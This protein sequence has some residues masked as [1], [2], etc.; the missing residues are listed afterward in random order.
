MFPVDTKILIVDDSSFARTVLKTGLRDLKFWK[1]LE[2]DSAKSAI[3]ILLEPEQKKD[4]VHLLIADV[5]M[6]EMNGLELLRWV[7]VQD[8]FRAMPVII[9]TT[10]Q[11]KGG[12]L[13]AGKLGVSHYMIKPFDSDTLRDRMTSTWEKHGQKYWE[14]LKKVPGT[15]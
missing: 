10:V 14:D 13:E 12:I 6:P 15:F 11:E 5:H 2:A 7:R 9:L 3:N 8:R 1:I 4:P